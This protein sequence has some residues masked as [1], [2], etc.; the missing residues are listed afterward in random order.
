MYLFKSTRVCEC[1]C[2][3][4]WQYQISLETY[5]T[6]HIF[7]NDSLCVHPP[8]HTIQMYMCVCVRV[9]LRRSTCLSVCLSARVHVG[10]SFAA[11]PSVCLYIPLAHILT[12]FYQIRTNS[13][14]HYLSV[15]SLCICQPLK[16]TLA[17]STASH[18]ACVRACVQP[19]HPT[20]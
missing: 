15:L 3:C 2:T 19:A 14:S 8:T 9:C 1:V 16:H 20:T 5:V 10:L 12:H 11:C 4:V 6:S 7:Y 13:L 18:G 17:R